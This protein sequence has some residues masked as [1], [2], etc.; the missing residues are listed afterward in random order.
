MR[1]ARLAALAATLTLAVGLAVATGASYAHE[2]GHT[3]EAHTV[4]AGPPLFDGSEFKTLIE[5][6]GASRVVRALPSTSPLAGRESRRSSLSYFAQL[7]DFQLAD[8]E[9]PA[10]VEFVDRGPSSAWRPQ[11]AFHPWGIDYS[12]RQL[13]QFTAASPHTQAGGAQAPMDLA[14]ITGDQS[15]NQQFNETVWVRQ[16]IEGGTPLTPNSG[17]TDYT[18]CRPEN[19]AELQARELAGEIPPEPTYMGV[20]DYDDLGF[21]APDYW[22]PDEPFGPQYGTFPNWL[23]TGKFGS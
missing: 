1:N 22:D 13:N 2:L 16:L 18:N 23:P 9:S 11:E 7:T 4:Q 21:K 20:Q 10:R 3:T 19:L 15:D 17:T 5:G 14:L 6:P 12:F 8:E